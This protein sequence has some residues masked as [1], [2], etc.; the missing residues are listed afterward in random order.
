MMI[1]TVSERGQISIPAAARKK[2]GIKPKSK[3]SIEIGEKEITIRPARSVREVY[4]IFADR[5]GRPADWE[6]ERA[7]A[8]A[9]VAS[10][11]EDE[12]ER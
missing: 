9:A 2:L 7:V 6:H 10:E 11:V 8:E 3:V 4:G 5:S 1:V 12:I